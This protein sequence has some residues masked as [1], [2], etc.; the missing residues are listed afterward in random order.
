MFK[1]IWY[2]IL[3]GVTLISYNGTSVSMEAPKESWHEWLLGQQEKIY[4][5]F[6][7]YELRMQLMKLLAKDTNGFNLVKNF[8]YMQNAYKNKLFVS[9][10]T[11]FIDQISVEK[12]EIEKENCKM[13]FFPDEIAYIKCKLLDMCSI[14]FIKTAKSFRI[15]EF[16]QCLRTKV[17]PTWKRDYQLKIVPNGAILNVYFPAK[18]KAQYKQFFQEFPKAQTVITHKYPFMEDYLFISLPILAENPNPSEFLYRALNLLSF[19]KNS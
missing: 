4:F 2:A 11:L 7:P 3:I 16:M 9:A 5:D 8:L 10:V 1:N 18:L 19:V 6:L 13:H 14:D 17:S 15:T 12:K